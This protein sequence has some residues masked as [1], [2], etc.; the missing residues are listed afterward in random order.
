MH[1]SHYPFYLK[2]LI[3]ELPF[4]AK[5]MR[6]SHEACDR[7]WRI[8]ELDEEFGYGI[9]GLT[10]VRL[11]KANPDAFQEF[12]NNWLTGERRTVYW[13]RYALRDRFAG[14]VSL[15]EEVA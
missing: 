13:L 10:Q 11:M 9:V 12:V 7:Y 4:L 5:Q 8:V 6:T 3:A 14:Q 2:Q 15:F 1:R